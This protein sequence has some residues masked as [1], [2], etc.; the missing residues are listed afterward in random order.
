MK[1]STIALTSLMLVLASSSMALATNGD[2]TL[3]LTALQWARG[4]AVV[5]APVDIPSMMYNPAAA[6]EFKVDKG[7]FDMSLGLLNAVRSIDTK[8]KSTESDSDNY[9][10]MGVGAVA[11]ASDKMFFGLAAGGVAGLGVDIPGGALSPAAP[12]AIV[13]TKSLFKIAPTMAYV[14]ND[15]LTLG[16]SPQI[17]YQTLAM[18]TPQFVLP[19]TGVFGLGGAVGAVYHITPTIQAGLSYT[20]KMYMQE[21][22]FNGS[23]VGVVNGA[24]AQI[25]GK[26]TMEMDV[27]QSV[28]GGVSFRPMPKLLLEADLKWIDFSDV[29]DRAELKGPTGNVIPI[30]FGWKDQVVYSLGAEYEVLPGLTVRSGYNYGASPIG[31]EDVTSNYGSIA[32]IEHHLSLGITKQWSPAVSTSASYTHG[33]TNKVTSNNAPAAL[34]PVSIEATQNIAYAQLSFRF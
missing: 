24:P 7:G 21:Y 4:G 11:R 17:G 27:P 9:L 15:K 16:V 33:F 3:G 19:Q 28:A 18:R 22:S 6:G 12:T 29:M 31:P 32:V 25:E 20:S 2:N 26:Y 8:T 34:A 30:L 1:R 23:A 5:A 10:A 13:T 14:V